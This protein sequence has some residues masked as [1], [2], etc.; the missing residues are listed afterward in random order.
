MG[1][2]IQSAFY[3]VARENLRP[4]VDKAEVV[5]MKMKLHLILLAALGLSLTSEAGSEINF[6]TIGMEELRA[7]LLPWTALPQNCVLKRTANAVHTA[8]LIIMHNPGV[9]G[10][11][12]F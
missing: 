3:P 4:F 5:G 12:V 7:A 1:V 6:E 8:K 9:N 10:R 2:Q 11:S